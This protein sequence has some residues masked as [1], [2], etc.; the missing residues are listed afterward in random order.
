M[1]IVADQKRLTQKER[2][3]AINI[4]LTVG[5]T[6]WDEPRDN[7]PDEAEEAETPYEASGISPQRWN[8]T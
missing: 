8:R 3:H 4:L 5:E 1:M 2:A 7:P 6:D